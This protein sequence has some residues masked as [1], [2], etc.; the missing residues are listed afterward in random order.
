MA[1]KKYPG[2]LTTPGDKEEAIY[3]GLLK[4]GANMGGYSKTPI[5]FMN[6]LSQAGQNF[7]TGYQDRIAQSKQDQLGDLEYQKMMGQMEAQQ[8]ALGKEK[9][10]QA[11]A[12]II[13]DARTSFL[14]M[15]ETSL[16]TRADGSG[17]TKSKMFER[18]YPDLVA[19]ERA[20]NM[21]DSSSGPLPASGIQYL[22][23]LQKIRFKYPNQFAA[24]GSPLPGTQA[25]ID[26]GDL[27][28]S[29]K[30]LKGVDLGDKFTQMGRYSSSNPQGKSVGP[31]KEIPYMANAQISKA[32]TTENVQLYKDARSAVK[33]QDNA[34]SLL[35]MLEA[36]NEDGSDVTSLQTGAFSQI[37]LDIQKA[38]LALSKN[39][40][41][42][43]KVE[44]TEF[45]ESK[46][47]SE[48]F[49]MISALGIG[50]RGLDTPAERVFMQKV[51]TGSIN[52]ERG[53]LIEMAKFRKQSA[54]R[55]IDLY[56]KR[57][58][59]GAFKGIKKAFGEDDVPIG[60]RTTGGAGNETLGTEVDNL[61][62]RYAPVDG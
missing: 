7:G 14:N 29:M 48:V 58:K 17:A 23:A 39:P 45:A 53:T 62:N 60:L 61:L 33:T 50:A 5:S 42:R 32:A 41:L 10:D 21:F 16:N 6:R 55:V 51:L 46:M 28:F 56:N 18:A 30:T 15:P 13:R 40:E 3:S 11:Q 4:M 26:M 19:K 57:Q 47:G 31:E 36:K 35:E 25:E 24:D 43:K 22:E 59:G 1:M 37:L 8:L 54:Q 34:S 2:L 44:A 27:E 52:L 12:A 9:E 20:E 38:R 49:G